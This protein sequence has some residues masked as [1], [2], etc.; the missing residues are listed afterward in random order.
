MPPVHVYPMGNVGKRSVQ[1]LELSRVPCVGEIVVVNDARNNM[2]GSW[3]VIE[4]FH[5]E[6]RGKDRA[7]G[8]VRV[9]PHK[10]EGLTI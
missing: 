6:P 3:R 7:V 10:V 9:A 1:T 5:C 2:H 8:E 4:V